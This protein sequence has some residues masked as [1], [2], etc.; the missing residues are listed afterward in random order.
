[1][2]DPGTPLEAPDLEPKTALDPT[3]LVALA[4][5]SMFPAVAAFTRFGQVMAILVFFAAF[6]G[7]YRLYTLL[8]RRVQPGFVMDFIA[9]IRTKPIYY[10]GK[11][12]NYAPLVERKK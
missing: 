2:R 6:I 11:P 9:W 1:M 12:K 7:S 5:L 10:A 4:A 8:I 3:T